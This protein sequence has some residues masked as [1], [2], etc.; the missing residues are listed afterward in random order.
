MN[1]VTLI[2]IVEEPIDEGAFVLAV[3]QAL[4]PVHIGF[5][6]QSPAQ[7]DRVVV[8]GSLREGPVELCLEAASLHILA[9]HMV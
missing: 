5:A 7:G 9:R 4:V 6:Q 2:G 8:E 3:E 1:S